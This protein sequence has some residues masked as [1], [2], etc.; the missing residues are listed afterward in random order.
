MPSRLYEYSSSPLEADG[1]D[2][3]E[4]DEP[5]VELDVDKLPSESLPTLLP[6]VIL[7]RPS[8]PF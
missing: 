7:R 4:L 1:G 5:L 6:R 2:E 3:E 8:G